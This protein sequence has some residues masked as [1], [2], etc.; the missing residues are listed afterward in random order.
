MIYVANFWDTTL[1]LNLFGLGFLVRGSYARRC[2]RRDVRS[3][4][5]CCRRGHFLL[6]EKS[7]SSTITEFPESIQKK[8]GGESQ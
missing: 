1:A 5:G 2:L 8:N 6:V 3:G 4:F 7:E